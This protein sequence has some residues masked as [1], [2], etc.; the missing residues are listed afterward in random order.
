[1]KAR[2][3]TKET[4][5]RLYKCNSSNVAHYFSSNADQ[6]YCPVLACGCSVTEIHRE[7]NDGNISRNK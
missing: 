5:Q 4:F 6:Y 2:E 1:M 3:A 7:A